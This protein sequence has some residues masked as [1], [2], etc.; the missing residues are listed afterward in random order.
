MDR[1]LAG[2]NLKQTPTS[3]QPP[4]KTAASKV[5]SA[6]AGFGT[7]QNWVSLYE[8]ESFHHSLR[9]TLVLL[10]VGSLQVSL[11]RGHISIRLEDPDLRRMALN[12]HCI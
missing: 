2:L 8:L 11:I 12:R 7:E 4:A 10:E 9:L 3:M 6:L 1:S 5:S